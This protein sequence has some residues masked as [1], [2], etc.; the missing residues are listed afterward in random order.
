MADAFDVQMA[1]TACGVDNLQEFNLRTSAQRIASKVFMDNFNIC[2]DKTYEELKDELKVYSRLTI[3]EGRIRILPGV[4]TK[5]RAFM[6]WARDCICQDLDPATV[7]FPV[8]QVANLLYRMETHDSFV[9]RNH[10]KTIFCPTFICFSVFEFL[11]TFCH[12]FM[13]CCWF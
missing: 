4:Q 10:F 7:A 11:S 9:K 5:I 8:D 1:L 3:N 13:C 6:Q 12:F 2:M